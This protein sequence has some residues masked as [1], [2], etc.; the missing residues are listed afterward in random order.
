MQN[1]NKVNNHLVQLNSCRNSKEFNEENKK[2]EQQQQLL[3]NSNSLHNME[4]NNKK[5]SAQT[6]RERF[7]ACNT[8][9]E[10]GNSN[11]DFLFG[12]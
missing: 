4:N 10:G 2:S 8:K 7:A 3:V 9:S 1:N 5:L 12:K 6:R 11:S